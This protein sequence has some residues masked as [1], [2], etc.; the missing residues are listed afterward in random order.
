M[1][2]YRRE[3]TYL[4]ADGNKTEKRNA[5]EVVVRV[6]DNNG[7]IVSRSVKGIERNAPT[8]NQGRYSNTYQGSYGNN[9]K[10]TYSAS[11]RTGHANSSTKW[12]C[13]NDETV[14]TGEV[15]VICG[16]H[17]PVKEEPVGKKE[18]NK[19][20]IQAIIGVLAILLIVLMIGILP[21]IWAPPKTESTVPT[22]KA[23]N[24][25]T[26]TP[27]KSVTAQTEKP[28]TNPPTETV[29]PHS[30]SW[31][32]ANCIE[33][34][35]CLSCGETR[36]V[37]NGHQW[38][39]ATITAPKTCQDCG[40][41]EGSRI[42]LAGESVVIGTYEQD[43]NTEN[44]KE[45]IYWTVLDYDENAGLALVLSDYCLDVV[46]FDSG[47]AAW[48]NSSIRR[49]LNNDFISSAFS[50]DERSRIASSTVNTPNN[51][52]YNTSGGGG[53][54]DMVFLLSYEEA[55][56]Y[57]TSKSVRQ[58]TPTDYCKQC[59][60]YDPER[61]A[62]EHSQECDEDEKGHTWWWLRSAGIDNTRAGNVVSKGVASTYGAKKSSSE[63]TIR[64]AMWVRL[65]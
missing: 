19:R 55:T 54:S 17:R 28:A 51:P 48:S 35:R 57:L 14:N 41:T 39:P 36:G 26:T 20:I 42:Y 34:E 32:D 16:I 1:E 58:G 47:T 37:A 7:N 33:P 65:G 62:K 13:P 49:W 24:R 46:P 40:V 44:G 52:D 8:N 18:C 15:C 5:V 53:S 12:I 64:P 27:T 3:Y 11:Q 23:T 38:V 59:G 29:Q 50:L 63:G 9:V 4:D 25:G 6:Y 31:L 60:C 61:Y 2:E 10:G 43:S 45:P 56:Y 21:G 30:H 22:E